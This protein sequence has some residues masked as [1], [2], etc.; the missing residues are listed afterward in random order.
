MNEYEP[1]LDMKFLNIFDNSFN[2]T[3]MF[4]VESENISGDMLY[5]NPCRE[6][7]RQCFD[8]FINNNTYFQC[9]TYQRD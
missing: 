8:A 9:C 7:D 2:N 3:N 4:F 1:I 6:D 5:N